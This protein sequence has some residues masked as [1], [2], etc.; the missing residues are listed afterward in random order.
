MTFVIPAVNNAHL[1]NRST[2]TLFL[3][4]INAPT[5]TGT[6]NGGNLP[7][8][9]L[10]GEWDNNTVGS[11]KGVAYDLAAAQAS[12]DV[13]A[14]TQLLVWHSQFNAPNRIMVDVVANGGKRIRIYSGAGTPPANYKEFYIGGNDTPL[15]S[16]ANG[17]IPFVIDRNDVSHEASA[18]TFDNTA[19]TAYAVLTDR[20]DMVGSNTNWNYEPRLYVFTTVKGNASTPTFSGTTAG[21]V[22]AVTLIQGTD[23]TTKLGNWVRQLGD[24]VFIDVAFR[25]GNN[26]TET[27]FDDGGLTIISPV[28][29]DATD[30]RN[31][32]TTQACRTYLD[33]RNNAADTALFTGTWIWGTRAPFDWDQDDLAVVTFTDPTF[34]G[35]GTFTLG[36]SITGAATWDDVDPVIFA[37]TGVDVDGSTFKNQNGSYALQMTAGAMDITDMRFEG[38]AAAHA[39]LI[40]TAGTYNLSNVFFDE[41]GTNDIETT[42]ASGVV[43]LNIS[44]GGTVPGVTVTGAGTVVVNNNVTV[45]VTITDT[46][47]ANIQNAR[48]E[49]TATE[50]VGTITSGDVLLT[51]LTNA[52]GRLETTTFNYEAAFN[53]SGLDIQVKARQGTSAPYYKPALVNGTILTSGYD[54]TIPLVLDQ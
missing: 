20:L 46:V 45:G 52:S 15:A 43:T 22:D 5:N 9:T 37:D 7:I 18:G 47:G 16:S 26:S 44:N 29:D 42:H 8:S 41:S 17:A 11:I 49:I 38:Y 40:D 21:P 19:V 3:T 53:P 33:L 24:V 1:V 25:I 31:R 32:L 51:G 54:N 10:S 23:Y 13:S 35:M 27:D 12:R 2:N 48:V 30:P 4:D 36:S 39:I 28:S 34:K 50:T 14:D 6:K